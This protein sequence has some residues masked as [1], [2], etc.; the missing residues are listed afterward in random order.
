[1]DSDEV[2]SSEKVS[3]FDKDH[4]PEWDEDFFKDSSKS[5]GKSLKKS[6][7][8]QSSYSFKIEDDDSLFN[9]NCKNNPEPLHLDSEISQTNIET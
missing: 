3:K 6:N 2:K 1:M 5:K 9:V 4:Y 8:Y 7:A